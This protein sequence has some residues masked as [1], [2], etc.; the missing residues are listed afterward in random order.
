M[1]YLIQCFNVSLLLNV[2]YKLN[3]MGG[4]VNIVMQDLFSFGK[5]LVNSQTLGFYTYVWKPK[6]TYFLNSHDYKVDLIVFKKVNCT[7]NNK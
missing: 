3:V 2:L 7:I 1:D 5:F 4:T 6:N